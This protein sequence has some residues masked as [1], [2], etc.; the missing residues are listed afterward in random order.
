MKDFRVSIKHE[1][2][3]HFVYEA[4]LIDSG[5][6]VYHSVC[7]CQTLTI[8]GQSFSLEY[9]TG[10]GGLGYDR[11]N[12]GFSLY[13]HGR[14]GDFVYHLLERDLEE[15]QDWCASIDTLEKLDLVLAEIESHEPTLDDIDSYLDDGHSFDADD[16]EL[17]DPDNEFGYKNAA[18][19]KD[20]E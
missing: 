7:V 15:A 1:S 2:S 9:Q 5:R 17:I 10:H 13:T 20:R 12:Q 14:D 19:L 4:L 8:C 3:E 6:T 18:R 11:P 16:Y